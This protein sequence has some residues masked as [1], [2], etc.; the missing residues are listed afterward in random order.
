MLNI[1]FCE[2][3]Q[4]QLARLVQLLEQY[5][6]STNQDAEVKQGRTRPKQLLEDL[7]VHENRPSLFF[8]DIQLEGC[9]MDGFQLA[10]EIR[11][12][13]P[14]SY[15]VF[16]TSK[17]ELAY[18]VFENEIDVLDCIVK[19]PKFFL[20]SDIDEKLWTRLGRI[21]EKIEKKRTEKNASKL[22]VECGRRIVEIEVKDIIYI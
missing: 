22:V 12:K 18:K 4:K 5:I 8:I 10:K 3:D 14:E 17:E 7:K 11:K 16:L 19:R 13:V 21:F 6:Q 20:C 1:Y 9:G 2:D 15:L